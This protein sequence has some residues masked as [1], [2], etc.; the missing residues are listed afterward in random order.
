MQEPEL[1][2]VLLSG[3]EDIQ[4][5]TFGMASA[6][7]A[8][9][10]GITVAVVLSMRGAY[11]AAPHASQGTSVPEFPT[12]ETLMHELH[13]LD[14][15]ILACSSCVDNYCPSPVNGDGLRTLRSGVERV[16]LGL[17]AIRMASART[18]VC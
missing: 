17:V 2:I 18:I 16:G 5:A 15:P 4:R 7:A 13:A 12:V 11:W 8:A 14:V 9:S 6:L 1:Q 3:P 10:S